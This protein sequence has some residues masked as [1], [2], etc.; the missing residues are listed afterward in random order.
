MTGLV[1]VNETSHTLYFKSNK[2]GVLEQNVYSIDYL[3]PSEPKRLTEGG[4]WNDA[5]MDKLGTRLLV[6]RSSPDQPPQTYLADDSGSRIL[7]V[8]QNRLD[9]AHPYAPFMAAHRPI[10]FG[11]LNA[12]DGTVLHWEMITPPLKRGKKYPVFFEHYGGPGTGQ[13]VTRSWGSPLRQPLSPSNPFELLFSPAFNR[14]FSFPSLMLELSY[15]ASA[16][17]TQDRIRT[18]AIPTAL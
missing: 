13:Q 17:W 9:A 7:W 1:G 14:W 4:Y 3:N 11:T 15:P 12:A 2:D 18:V 6:T 5:V 16:C 10:Q 8:E